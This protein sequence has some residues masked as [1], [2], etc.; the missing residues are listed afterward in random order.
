MSELFSPEELQIIKEYIIKKMSIREI[1]A[2]HEGFGRTRVSNI[3]D[4][5][6]NS[7]EERAIEIA[8]RKVSQKNHKEV[9]SIEEITDEE[10]TEEQI[11]MAYREIIEGRKTLTSVAGALK[12]NRETI[13]KAII[14]YLGDD[15][16]AIKEFGKVLKDNQNYAT[17]TKFF[18]N[19]SEE[20]KIKCIFERLNLRRK[21]AGRPVYTYDFLERKYDRLINYFEKRNLKIDNPTAKLSKADVLRMMFD[22]PT[23]LSMSLTDKIKPVINSLDYKHLGFFDTSKVLRQNASILGTSLERINL[24]MRVLKD[25]ETLQFALKKPRTFRTSPELMYA[26]IKL[27]EQRDKQGVPFITTKKLYEQYMLVPEKAC[28]LNNIRDQYGDDEYF[29]GR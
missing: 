1:A 2:L 15:K 27:W 12:K 11:E 8:L 24:Q 28:E 14:D 7:G 29:D 9:S 18:D 21:L 10:L 5:Y 20:D 17:E 19:L 4:K 13:K 22:Y 6:A 25:T 16:I 26:L 23:M 3:I